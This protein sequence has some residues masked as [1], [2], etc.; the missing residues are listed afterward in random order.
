[1]LYNQFTLDV[2]SYSTLYDIVVPITKKEKV[3][4]VAKQYPAVSKCLC[5]KE[6]EFFYN[7]DAGLFVC[8]KGHMAIKR[9]KTGRTRKT[10]NPQETHYFD[11]NHCQPAL[12]KW[13]VIKKG[14]SLKGIP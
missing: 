3:H 5:K 2:N 11:I 8:P 6:D 4:L 10:Y 14:L 12:Q 1:M 9:A 7:K 13:A